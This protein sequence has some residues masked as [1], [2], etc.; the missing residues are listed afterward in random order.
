VDVDHVVPLKWAHD[1]GGGEWSREKKKRF[2]NDPLNLLVVHD[3]INRIKGAKGIDK[4]MPSVGKERYKKI[5]D[6]VRRKYDF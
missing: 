1:H 6:E 2:A 3:R 4:W 5:W